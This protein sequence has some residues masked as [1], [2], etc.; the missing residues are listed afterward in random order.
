MNAVIEEIVKKDLLIASVDANYIK[1]VL[2]AY[3]AMFSETDL[4]EILKGRQ[5][6]TEMRGMQ[7]LWRVK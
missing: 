7:T 4:Q 3:Y 6:A 1:D 5:E 2:R